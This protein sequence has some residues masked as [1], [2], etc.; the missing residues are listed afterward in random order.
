MLCYPH[1]V[2][3]L[4]LLQNLFFALLPSPPPLQTLT[5]SDSYSATPNFQVPPE[6][7]MNEQDYDGFAV[8][9]WALGVVM[10]M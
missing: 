8:D 6:V 9:V 4:I 2:C 1:G 10:F 5:C 7:A 3:L